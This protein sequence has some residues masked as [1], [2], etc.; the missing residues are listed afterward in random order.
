M[1][2]QTD[3][4]TTDGDAPRVHAFV[5]PGQGSQYVGMGAALLER[6]PAAAA[7]MERADAALGFP[8]SQLIA[9]GPA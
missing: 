7:V 1:S 8:L 3:H 4:P 2:D 6:S 9:E 5:F